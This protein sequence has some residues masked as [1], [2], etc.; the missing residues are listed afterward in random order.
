MNNIVIRRAGKFVDVFHGVEGWEIWTRFVVQTT[1]S[2]KKI[3]K[4]V[5]G[6]TLNPDQFHFVKQAIL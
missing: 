4:F 3:L 2:K 1:L 6:S 5:A